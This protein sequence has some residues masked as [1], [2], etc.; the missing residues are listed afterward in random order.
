MGRKNVCDRKLFI[1]KIRLLKTLKQRLTSMIF[2][3]I[4]TS[5]IKVVKNL[6]GGIWI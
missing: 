3:F 2:R 4:I 6:K 1:N 5:K